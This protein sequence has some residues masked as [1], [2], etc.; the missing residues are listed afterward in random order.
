[1]AASQQALLNHIAALGTDPSQ[2]GASLQLCSVALENG[3][4]AFESRKRHL[5]MWARSAEMIRDLRQSERSQTQ[6]MFRGAVSDW[7][8]WEFEILRREL[9]ECSGQVGL[10]EEEESRWVLQIRGGV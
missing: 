7:D 9:E 3:Q 4:S 8:V 10:A 1:M 2:L 5:Q 6:E